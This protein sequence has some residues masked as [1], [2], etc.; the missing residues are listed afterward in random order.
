MIRAGAYDYQCS[1]MAGAHL[2]ARARAVDL[3]CLA[4][5]TLAEPDP[6]NSVYELAE[7]VRVDGL[8]VAAST[9]GV[10]EDGPEVKELLR[11]LPAV[12]TCFI[13]TPAAGRQV[14]T[15]D[16]VSGVRELTLHLI[17]E[18]GRRHIAFIQGTNCESDARQAGYLEALAA[19]G[20]APDPRLIIPGFFSSAGGGAAVARIFDELAAPCDAIVAANDWMAIGALE[21]LAGRGMSV[22]EAVSVVGFDDIDQSRFLTPPLTTIRQ[23]ARQLGAEAVRLLLDAV[24]GHA[25]TERRLLPTSMRLR[26]SCGCFGTVHRQGNGGRAPKASS[27]GAHSVDALQ[28]R[29]SPESADLDQNTNASEIA[30]AFEHELKEPSSGRF[31][32]ALESLLRR[33]DQYGNVVAWHDTITS[34]RWANIRRL[35]Q[36]PESWLHAESLFQRAHIL[37]GDCSERLH[38]QRTLH[39]DATMRALDLLATGLRTVLDVPSLRATLLSHLPALGVPRMYISTLREPG[40]LGADS[41]LLCAFDP[42]SGGALSIDTEPRFS[43]GELLPAGVAPQERTSLILKPLFSGAE[44]LGFCLTEIDTFEAQLYETLPELVSTTLRAIQLSKNLV[45][46]ATRRQR[47]EREQMTKELEIAARIQTAILPAQRE[48][49]G[50]EIAACMLPAAE[51]GGDYFDILP[52]AEGAW[53]G[54]GDVAGHGL[55]TGLVMLM[56]QSAAA[57]A[58]RSDPGQLPSRAWKAVNTVLCDNIRRRITQNEHVTLTL[59]RYA[60]SGELHFSGGHEDI[61]I[62][63]GRSGQSEQISPPGIWA[64]VFDEAPEQEATDG[65]AV[66]ER[67]DV[68][69]LH[70]DGVTEARNAQGEQFGL[71]RLVS[72]FEQLATRS[73]RDIHDGILEVVRRWM[74]HQEDDISLLVARY[75]G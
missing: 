23:P 65:R 70:T 48:V 32:S 2:E 51:V 30:A 71:E 8:I 25:D 43:T 9:L 46:E 4:G 53:L 19:D 61:L 12:P 52:T 68:F 72:T 10:P 50:L 15:V 47:A 63:R 22:P 3:V 73:V 37:I 7:H 55:M 64:G 58:I 21:A 5:G 34:L 16:N 35:V 60:R 45:E 6:R 38:A 28:A 44:P 54:I 75:T 59:I 17:R 39:R 67:G 69:M 49:A 11:R 13:G 56:V 74:D 40:G 29:S 41:H 27:S 14:V 66:L 33:S 36:Q 1:I 18:H 20:L 26:R 62:Y 57:A 31:L 24:Q 42:R